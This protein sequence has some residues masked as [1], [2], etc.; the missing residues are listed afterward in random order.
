MEIQTDVA[1]SRGIKQSGVHRSISFQEGGLTIK[2]LVDNRDKMQ[3]YRLRN[4]IFCR[5]LGWA[6]QSHDG[7]E[8]D[9][10]DEHAVFLGVLNK[11]GRLLAFLRF[12]PA[13]RTFMIENEFLSLVDPR[14][15]IRKE[16][17]TAELSRLCVAP[18]ARKDR[19]AGNFGSLWLYTGRIAGGYA[20][21]WAASR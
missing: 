10:Y 21:C 15:A 6:L 11:Q 20:D 1:A 14:H 9:K 17:D 12:I 4:V 13:D 18:E 2:N 8:I 19:V 7:L 3:A 16:S 5:E